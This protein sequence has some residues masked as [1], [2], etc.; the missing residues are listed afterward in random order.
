MSIRAA[1][2]FGVYEFTGTGFWVVWIPGLG[3]EL[4]IEF[5]C[6]V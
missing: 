6:L 5:V 1:D 2:G 4:G 3:L